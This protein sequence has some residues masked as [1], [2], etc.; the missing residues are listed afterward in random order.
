MNLFSKKHGK[1]DAFYYKNPAIF[2]TYT[3]N[4]RTIATRLNWMFKHITERTDLNKGDLKLVADEDA[5][6]MIN[7]KT[8]CRMFVEKTGKY[9]LWHEEVLRDIATMH[10]MYDY[11]Q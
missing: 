6:R 1:T 11:N 10:E 4:G 8:G 7:R 2:H 3:L 9:F 5:V